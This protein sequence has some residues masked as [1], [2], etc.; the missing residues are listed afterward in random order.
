[1]ENK[2]I[3]CYETVGGPLSAASAKSL[4]TIK[5]YCENWIKVGTKTD[6]YSR[7][8]DMT[9]SDDQKYHY[10]RKCY[11]SLCHQV[12]LTRAVQKKRA[13]PGVEASSSKQRKTFDQSLCVFCQSDDKTVVH[14]VTSCDMGR[15]PLAIKNSSKSEDICARLAFL[16]NEKDAFA[17][18]MKYHINCLRKE[19]RAI[20]KCKTSVDPIVEEDNIG[21]AIS[22]IEIVNIVRSVITENSELELQSVD[23]NSIHNTYK[24]LLEENGVTFNPE[25][26]YKP[27]I[28]KH[29][30]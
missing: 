6:V 2:C 15:K 12:H 1:M 11:Q 25:R 29:T 26:N 21:K 10:H 23:M 16:Y 13:R 20:E 19:T 4:E 24:S 18:N 17:Q 9:F 5:T 14:S 27:H 8:K 22:D 7:V 30:S 3:I 28:K